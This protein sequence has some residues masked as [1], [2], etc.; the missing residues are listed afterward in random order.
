[1][2]TAVSLLLCM[3]GCGRQIEQ[4]IEETQAAETAEPLAV[5]QT[6][7]PT[8]APTQAPTQRPTQ[9]AKPTEAPT[10]APTQALT[11]AASGEGA[12]QADAAPAP[13]PRWRGTVQVC[14]TTRNVSI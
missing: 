8:L 10:A 6:E 4:P 2:L 5:T 3:S 9:A 7:A 1:M 14:P 11:Q 12:A 13:F